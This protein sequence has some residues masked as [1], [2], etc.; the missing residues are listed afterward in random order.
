MTTVNNL[1]ATLPADQI[2][3]GALQLFDFG[4]LMIT[5]Q[6]PDGKIMAALLGEEDEDLAIKLPMR[7]GET[8]SELIARF[9]DDDAEF[10]TMSETLLATRDQLHASLAAEKAEFVTWARS[11]LADAIVVAEL[12]LEMEQVTPQTAENLKSSAA[13]SAAAVDAMDGA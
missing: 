2:V 5:E 6:A 8:A 3:S 7:T 9:D 4:T 11:T 12:L 1:P 10:C 13:I